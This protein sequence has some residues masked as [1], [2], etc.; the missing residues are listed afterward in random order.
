MMKAYK[1]T[2]AESSVMQVVTA[3]GSSVIHVWGVLS[4][5]ELLFCMESAFRNLI[6]FESV[7]SL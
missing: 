6:Y 7:H 4:L 1:W 2:R 3:E 5:R